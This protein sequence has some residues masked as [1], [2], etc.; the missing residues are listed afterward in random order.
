MCPVAPY[1]SR[2]SVISLSLFRLG[3]SSASVVLCVILVWD[4][5]VW[6]TNFILCW[7]HSYRITRHCVLLFVVL[8]TVITLPVRYYT[9]RGRHNSKLPYFIPLG[10]A[11]GGVR[12]TTG[13]HSMFPFS[14]IHVPSRHEQKKIYKFLYS[15]NPRL[16]AQSKKTKWIG[17]IAISHGIYKQISNEYCKFVYSFLLAPFYNLFNKPGVSGRAI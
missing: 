6:C 10:E 13:L 4:G 8:L 12:L 17:D 3:V 2:V 15:W 1:C 14:Q 5:V 9:Q 16:N 11:T 7:V